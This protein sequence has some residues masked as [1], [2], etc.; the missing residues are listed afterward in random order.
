MKYIKLFEQFLFEEKLSADQKSL[1]DKYA[2]RVVWVMQTSDLRTTSG[3]VNTREKKYNTAA[4]N[5]LFINFFTKEDYNDKTVVV[6]NDLPILYYG[7]SKDTESEQFLKNKKVDYNKLY[8]KRDI[9]MISGDKTIFGK[10]FGKYNWLPKTVFSKEEALKGDVGFPV[11][12][13]IKNGHSGVGIEKFDT[14]KELDE[15][16]EKFDLFCQ[17][18]DFKR[19]YRVIFCQDKLIAINERVPTI[20]DDSSINTKKVNDKIKFTYVY[21]DL[22][23]IDKDFIKQCN[24]ICKDIKKGGL[25]L[26]FW[27]LDIVVDGDKKLWVMETSSALGMGSVKMC[28]AYRA[29]YEDYYKEKLPDE[30]LEHIY[31]EFIVTGHQNYWPKYKKEIESSPCAMDYTILTD[32]KHPGGYRY[33]FNLDK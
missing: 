30:F 20:K 12:A 1:Y 27:S 21:Q 4:K 25:D 26:N 19:E 29:I 2:K 23:K 6:P 18:I 13:K 9:L 28:E 15:S 24:A 8:N 10:T 33:F 7:G 22:N 16:V 3:D 31:K 11:I 17:Y 32:E 14:K 5:S